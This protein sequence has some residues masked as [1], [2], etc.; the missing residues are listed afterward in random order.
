V[1][2]LD[3]GADDCLNKP[4]SFTECRRGF[5]AAAA[6]PRTVDTVLQVADPN[7]IAWNAR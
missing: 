4:F 7:W 3:S 5:C 6:G 2:A 1:Q